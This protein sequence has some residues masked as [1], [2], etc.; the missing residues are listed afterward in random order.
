MSYT[1]IYGFNQNGTA[2][3]QAEVDNAWRGAMAIWAILEE[4][5]LPPYIPESVKCANWYYHGMSFDEVVQKIG[6]KP[7]RLIVLF[8]DNS[9]QEIWDLADSAKVSTIDKIVLMTTFDKVIV[10]REK[11]PQVIDAFNAF[12]GE[13]SL[14]EQAVILQEMLKN[15]KCI[16]VGWAQTSISAYDWSSF[17]FNKETGDCTPY[18]CLTQ[19]EHYWL[20][21]D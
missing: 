16:A 19:N 6:F 9:I 21:E 5:Y 18:N 2:Y 7:T 4:R 10:K 1:S 11:L 15:E 14:K 12:E 20:F 3:L 17:N 13:T 8:G